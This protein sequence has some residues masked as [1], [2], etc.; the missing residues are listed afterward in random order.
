MGLVDR[1]TGWL[2][3]NQVQARSAAPFN[4]SY[5]YPDLQTQ[6]STMT[7]WRRQHAGAWR[8]PSIEE[9]L[10]V[11][12]ILR[13]VT[14]ISN[15][16]GQLTVRGYRDGAPMDD[17]PRIITRPDPWT[18]PQVF[19]RDSA[20]NMATR[21]EVVWYIASRDND[22]LASALVV[23][24]LR[25]LTIEQ[26]PRDRLRAEYRWGNGTGSVTSTRWS[27]ANPSGRFV[28]VTYLAEPGDLRGRGPLQLA[29]AA[30]SVSVESQQWAA[31]FYA[32]GGYPSVMLHSED[33]LEDV[34]AQSLKEQ[35]ASSPP[36]TPLVT[37]GGLNV[38]EF[39]VNPQ[40]AQMLD[41]RSHQDGEGARMFGVPGTLVEFNAP[42]SSLTYQN[43]G[44]VFT[45]FVKSCLAPNYLEP[46]EQALSDLLPRSTVARFYVEGFYRADMRTR[47]EVYEIATKVIGV[48]EAA[49]WAREREGLAPGDV[50]YKPVPFA[51]PAAVNSRMPIIRTAA[52]EIRC[53]GLVTRRRS[54][55]VG[56][57]KCNRLLTRTGVL[58]DRC[59][60]FKKEYAAA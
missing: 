26:N 2:A 56:M 28:H 48:D 32:R 30:V 4:V 54:G 39:G 9:A 14:L 11:P 57:E 10:G 15:T 47:W 24:P 7:G 37:S 35:W 6:L 58:P 12:S 50:E 34:D 53:D 42:G 18:T 17:S 21:G 13:C 19:Y 38:T 20:Y 33:E 55:I 29:Q 16:T 44:E 45:L 46:M 49:Q 23:V 36:N 31:N 41:A 3:A 5:E 22:G 8:L 27:P 43:I 52:V 25:E 51:P 59:P 40:G 60:K 1:F